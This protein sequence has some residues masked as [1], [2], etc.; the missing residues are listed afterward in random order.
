MRVLQLSQ[1]LRGCDTPLVAMLY[2]GGWPNCIGSKHSTFQDPLKHIVVRW[3]PNEYLSFIQI[4]A[5]IGEMLSICPTCSLKNQASSPDHSHSAWW[6]KE[7]ANKNYQ[8]I[9][10]VPMGILKPFCRVIHY[11]E[12]AIKTPLALILCAEWGPQPRLGVV[13]MKQTFTGASGVFSRG[14]AAGRR[15]CRQNRT[16]YKLAVHLGL[17]WAAA[18]WLH[19]NCIKIIE[20]FR[21]EK[22]F[23]VHQVQL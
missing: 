2:F 21:L 17:T 4:G 23:Q 9:S 16:S 15:R 12:R 14:K 3:F 1:L 19:A 10:C 11:L 6:G 22:I 13:K 7:C 5:F 8:R 20:G 18:W